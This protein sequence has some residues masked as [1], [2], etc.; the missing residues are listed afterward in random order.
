[1]AILACYV[2]FF[3][4]THPPKR[5]AVSLC[6]FMFTTRRRC[7]EG[8][9]RQRWD[10]KNMFGKQCKFRCCELSSPVTPARCCTVEVLPVP[11]SPTNRTGSLLATHTA[12]CSSSTEEGRVAA[13]VWFSLFPQSREQNVSQLWYKVSG[14]CQYTDFPNH[15]NITLFAFST[16]IKFSYLPYYLHPP[17]HT[18]THY[19]SFRLQRVS[20]L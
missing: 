18:H 1:M 20:P 19:F 6:W 14:T 10:G 3:L 8:H 5:S 9:G 12:T 2:F 17:S 11:V 13:N 4:T 16:K 7:P 15:I